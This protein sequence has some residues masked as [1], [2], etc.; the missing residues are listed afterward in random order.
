MTSEK[1][2]GFT[3]V[4]TYVVSLWL[5]NDEDAYSRA[6]TIA[7]ANPSSFVSDKEMMDFVEEEL[8]PNILDGDFQAE[9]IRC[10]A[11]RVNWREIVEA[12]LKD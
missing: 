1:Y 12:F 10:A 9:M 3:N 6:R 2:K 7:Q 8:F 11:D 4:E 5:S